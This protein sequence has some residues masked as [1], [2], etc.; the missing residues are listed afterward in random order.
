MRVL[1]LRVLT[2]RTKF[3]PEN[4][5]SPHDVGTSKTRPPS[6][7][8]SVEELDFQNWN[9][10]VVIATQSCVGAHCVRNV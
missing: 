9:A 1:T 8:Y 3:A 4:R 10:H 6:D 7:I 5:R 2:L